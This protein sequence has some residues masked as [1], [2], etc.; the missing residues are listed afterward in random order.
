MFSPKYTI[1]ISILTQDLDK[2]FKHEISEAV[3]DLLYKLKVAID[4]ILS[5]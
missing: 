5:Q 1:I 2:A 4:H 3:R